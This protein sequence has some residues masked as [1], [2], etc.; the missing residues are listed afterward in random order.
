MNNIIIDALDYF[1]PRRLDSNIKFEVTSEIIETM[2]IAIINNIKMKYN[3][4]GIVTNGDFIW[5]WHLNIPKNKFVKS[6]KLLL[7]AIEKEVVT[8]QDTYVKTILTTSKHI[9]H[10]NKDDA[11][12]AIIVA[13]SVYLTKAHHV[14]FYY[15]NENYIE[16]YGL[17]EI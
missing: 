13:L 14:Y 15:Y 7:Y 5:A 2:P 8:L 1:Y 9:L 6:K 10:K 4:L 11:T 16:I 3:V 12:F 17:Y